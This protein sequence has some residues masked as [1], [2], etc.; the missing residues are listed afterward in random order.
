MLKV[1]IWTAY[2]QYLVTENISLLKGKEK[3]K[4]AKVQSHFI[5][6]HFNNRN[7]KQGD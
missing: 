5:P 7:E 1:E 3:K 2:I 4:E 6:V